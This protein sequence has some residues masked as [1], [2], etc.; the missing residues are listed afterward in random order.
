MDPF[1]AIGLASNIIQFIDY[2]AKVINLVS[3]QILALL[4]EIKPKNPKPKRQSTLAAFKNKLRQRETGVGE[5]AG[6]L[7]KPASD[8]L[9][10]LTRYCFIWKKKI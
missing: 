1:A 2:S 8:Q 5:E 6:T 9:T 3:N 7:P 4:A 10:F